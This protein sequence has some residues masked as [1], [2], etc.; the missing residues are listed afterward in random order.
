MSFQEDLKESQKVV[1]FLIDWLI[2][3]GMVAH[4]L[5]GK[6]EQRQ[7]DLVYYK[8]PTRP[9]KVEVKY[10]KKAADTG[11]LCFELGNSKKPTGIM[12]SE[13]DFVYYVIPSKG[14]VDVLVFK[15]GKLRD[16][17]AESD[18][19]RKTVGGDRKAFQLALV[20]RSLIESDDIL[21]AHYNISSSKKYKKVK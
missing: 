20:K 11:N 1:L 17:L 3:C 12:S 13:S 2:D 15:T 9:V 14:S 4:E 10:D 16:F 21:S 19:V 6:K 18:K 8:D 7:G 5:E